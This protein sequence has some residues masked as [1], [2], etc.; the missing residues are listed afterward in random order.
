VLPTC[1]RQSDEESL[2]L[3]DLRTEKIRPRARKYEVWRFLVILSAASAK[4]KR[5]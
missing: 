1:R 3:F 5:H 4:K 2:F